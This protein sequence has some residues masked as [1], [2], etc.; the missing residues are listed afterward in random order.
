MRLWCSDGS[1][2]PSEEPHLLLRNAFLKQ[3]FDPTGPTT[4][5]PKSCEPAGLLRMWERFGNAV[6]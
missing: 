2:L 5:S 1:C 6:S 3:Y 4:E